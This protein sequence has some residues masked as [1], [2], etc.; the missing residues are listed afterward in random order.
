MPRVQWNN[1]R[2]DVNG[3]ED[4]RCALVVA[5]SLP[6]F[7]LPTGASA[8]TGGIGPALV[9]PVQIDSWISVG[10]DGLVTVFTGKEELGTGTETATL[11]MAADELD[12]TMA[13]V[14][15]IQCDTWLT[16]NQGT[17][18]GSQSMK[19][20]FKSGVRIAA[21]E[22]RLA[23]LNMASTQLGVPVAQLTVTDGVVSVVGNSSK[24]VTY[25]SLIGNQKFNLKIT[26]KAVPKTPD[27]YKIVGTSVAR[28]DIPDK[29]LA[30]FTYTQD[31]SVPGMLHGRVVRPPSLDAKLVSVDGFGG[32]K[33]PGLVKVV[34]LNN[35]VGVVAEREEQAIAAAAA[36][37]VTWQTTPLP[38]QATI[39]DQIRN[40]PTYNDRNLILTGNVDTAI[41]GAA[42]QR[43]AQ[44]RY[45]YQMHGSMGAS[46]EVADVQATT[47]TVWTASQDVYG[48]RGMLAT[49]LNMPVQNV[50]V[51]YVEGSGC[52]GLN[53]ADNIGIDAALMSQA[54]GKPVRVQYMR[55]DEHGWENYGSAVVAEVRGAL[56]TTG[57]VQAWDYTNW[58]VGRGN[59]PGPPG[60]LPAGVLA[61]FPEPPHGTSPP[62]FPPLGPDGS[63]T[64]TWYNFP[65]HRV[66]AHS[67][68]SRFFTGPL[69]SPSRIQNTFANES[70]IDELAA[71]AGQDPVQFRLKYLTDQRLITVIQ[72]AA[73]LA[74]WKSR[75]S[76]KPN[77]KGRLLTGRGIAAMQYESSDAYSAVIAQVQVDT[78]TGKVKVQHVWAAQE[79]GLTLNP[80]GMTHQAEGCVIQGVSRSLKE[81]L[82]WT[83]ARI[84][85]QDWATYP[86]LR[87]PEMP[88]FDFKIVNRP[89]LP[90]VGA[91]EVVI[92]AMPGAIANAIFDATNV[93]LRQV[94][95]TPARVRAGLNGG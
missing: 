46:C 11:Q 45:P 87:F 81:E 59:R 70:F 94:P 88:K 3:S 18:S 34:T 5:I 32:K 38:D 40:A 78:K 77:R 50:H 21:A 16:V 61:G 26:G 54:V 71:A 68:A 76:P 41:P 82:K 28:V 66:V 30:R 10:G 42:V 33:T 86:V 7:M 95:F 73:S 51:I 49:L 55:H 17:S 60:N 8:Q 63:N 25:A 24:S 91:G 64:V 85:T 74:N 19:T 53:G 67:V 20:E 48:H 89:D 13:K 27:Q 52:Y 1:F 4:Y 58:V 14:K 12:V 15:L 36:L 35:F 43:S 65:N 29:I 69:R 47:A 57:N 6:R 39:Y 2:R 83:T 92:T 37:K 84:T 72:T 56:D 23:L 31:I 44:Y 62:P 75:P 93:R 9:D 22:A 80:A 79:C 90:V